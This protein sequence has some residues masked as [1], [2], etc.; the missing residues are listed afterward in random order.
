MIA[1]HDP[2]HCRQCLQ[3]FP[4]QDRQ[5]CYFIFTLLFHFLPCVCAVCV[6]TVQIYFFAYRSIFCNDI[7]PLEV[8]TNEAV[9]TECWKQSVPD[10]ARC[11][12][13]SR[14]FVVVSYE[15]HEVRG[16]NYSIKF[17]FFSIY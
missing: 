11:V 13:P 2:V 14:G 4:L 7:Y 10:E 17:I 15:I 16:E 8:F 3:A 9:Q 6:D 1:L 12:K 5:A